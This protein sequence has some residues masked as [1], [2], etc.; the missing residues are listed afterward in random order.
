[1]FI[2]S[3]PMFYI[4]MMTSVTIIYLSALAGS[5]RDKKVNENY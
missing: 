5:R 1:M 4:C 2:L 3:D